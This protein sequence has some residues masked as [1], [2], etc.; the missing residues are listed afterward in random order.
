MGK[1]VY[2]VQ[3]K[4][5]IISKCSVDMRSIGSNSY[6]VNRYEILKFWKVL[7]HNRDC[8][9]LWVTGRVTSD[10]VAAVYLNS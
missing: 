7:Q 6:D 8:G 2:S 10:Y 1:G 4:S 5:L 9:C 3:G